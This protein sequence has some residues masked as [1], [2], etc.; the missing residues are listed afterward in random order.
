MQYYDSEILQ[1][2][3]ALFENMIINCQFEFIKTL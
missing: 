2:H 1:Q 3:M